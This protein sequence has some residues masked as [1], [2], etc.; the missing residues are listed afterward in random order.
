MTASL[1]LSLALALALPAEAP[2][3][4]AYRD[5]RFA[6]AL[7]LYEETLARPEHASRRGT[8]LYDMGNCFY[9]LDRPAEALWAYLRAEKRLP[10][11]PE[12][13]FNRRLAEKRLRLDDAEPSRPGRSTPP[14]ATLALASALLAL[15][16]AGSV[17]ARRRPLAPRAATAA[18]ALAGLLLTGR[19][20]A[21]AWF[22][23]A[24]E[25]VVIAPET[26]LRAEPSAGA[27]AKGSL[28]AGERVRVEEI[29]PGFVRV[30]RGSESGWA[31]HGSV[32]I[33]D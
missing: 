28:R 12:V 9:R 27:A 2:A 31:A 32:G 7:T 11:D 15:G 23:P 29:V 33:V 30:A 6:E 13:A 20:A 25:G 5:G 26:A 18:V 14:G 1:A 24:V 8:I 4:R 21:A 10:H 3:E 22:A 17:L 19:L 16:L